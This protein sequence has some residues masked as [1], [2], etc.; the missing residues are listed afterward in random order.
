MDEGDFSSEL[1]A[2][3]QDI[4]DQSDRLINLKLAAV[5]TDTKLW[6]EAIA[7]FYVVFKT[8]EEGLIRCKDHAHVGPLL[9]AV[10]GAFRTKAFERDLQFYLGDDWK[11][12][13]SSSTYAKEY[14]SRIEYVIANEP[15]LLVAYVHSMYLAL[16]AGGQIIK[17]I[18]KKTLGL[19]D[20]QGLDLF[21]FDAVERTELR[22]SIK[23]TIDGLQLSRQQKDAI[24]EEKIRVFRM[25]NAIANNIQT[26]WVHY[27]RIFKFVVLAIGFPTALSFLLWYM[28]K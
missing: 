25:N 19:T 4:H 16:L 10:G 11:S 28:S 24:I 22:R 27:K 17:R 5:L 20:E 14:C 12:H 1:T 3:T 2:K 15:T 13:V 8:I 7:E 23:A 26:S 6:A 9:E 18:V 21:N